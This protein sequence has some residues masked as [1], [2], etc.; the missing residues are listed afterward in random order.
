M[1][2]TTTA[3][4]PPTKGHRSHTSISVD[5]NGAFV[6]AMRIGDGLAITTAG[7]FV[8]MMFKDGDRVVGASIHRDGIPALI[9]ELQRLS[10]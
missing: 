6:A 3:L 7:V 8:H 4:P 9:A 10:A 5:R 1:T 2:T